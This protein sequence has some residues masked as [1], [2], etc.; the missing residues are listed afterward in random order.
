MYFAARKT[1]DERL[2]TRRKRGDARPDGLGGEE[3][4]AAHVRHV[5]RALLDL[6]MHV[7]GDADG[8][9]RGSDA[10][11]PPPYHSGLHSC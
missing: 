11:L 4:A 9:L 1:A 10:S 6:E 5:R 7:S 8:V 3:Q 2:Q